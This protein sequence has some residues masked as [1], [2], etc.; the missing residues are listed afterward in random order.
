M[1]PSMSASRGSF[2]LLVNVRTCVCVWVYVFDDE[3][4][5]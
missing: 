3:E 1:D 5:G 2:F 4:T